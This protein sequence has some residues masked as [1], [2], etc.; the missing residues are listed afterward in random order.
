MLGS[1]TVTLV[2]DIVTISWAPQTTNTPRSSRSDSV[3]P[4]AGGPSVARICL[5]STGE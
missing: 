2:V 5:R 1:A 4:T 3:T